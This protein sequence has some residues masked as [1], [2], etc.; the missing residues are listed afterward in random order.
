MFYLY[1]VNIAAHSYIISEIRGRSTIGD[2]FFGLFVH[3][4]RLINV[5]LNLEPKYNHISK[6]LLI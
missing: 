5:N 3:H 2:I 1:F 4:K 6:I